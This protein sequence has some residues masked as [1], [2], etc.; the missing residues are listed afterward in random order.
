MIWLLVA[1]SVNFE[2]GA[3][4]SPK[5][6]NINDTSLKVCTPAT[7]LSVVT[8]HPVPWKLGWVAFDFDG[9]FKAQDG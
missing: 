1:Q 5:R 4:S 3:S 9:F 6:K 7:Q 8:C 2:Q